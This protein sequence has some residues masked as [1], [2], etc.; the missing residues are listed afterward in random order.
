[1]HLLAAQP[2]GFVDDA[3]VITRIAQQP[4]DI[5]V[6]SAADT[7]LALLAAAWSQL[8][9]EAGTDADTLGLPTLRLA[10]L[11]HLRQPASVDLYLDDVLQHARVIVIDHLGGESYWPY[12]TERI[13]ELCRARGIA[14]AMFS[15][16]TSEDRNLL[17]KGTVEAEIARTLW[18]YLRE[19]GAANAR[20]FHRYLAATFFGQPLQVEP[21]RPLPTVA[22]F[23]PRHEVATVENWQ[24]DW[25]PGAPCVPLLFYRAHLQAGNTAVFAHLCEALQAHG[26]NPL[27]LALLS[28]K[29][30]VGVATVRRLCAEHRAALILNT[31][32]F[33]QA[34]LDS[35]A[36]S[37]GWQ[38]ELAAA[39]AGLA[40]D[41]P[42]LQLILSGG[43]EAGWQEDPQGLAPRDIAMHVALPEVDGRIITRAI[44]FK[45]LDHHNPLTQS[46]VVQYRAHPERVA[47]VAE[48]A[49]RWC[50]LRA[51][52]NAD[53]RLALVLANYPTREGRLGNGVG[54]DTPASVIAIL[55]ALRDEGYALG[56][57][58]ADGDALMARLK[59]GIT[60]DPA[61][62]AL[63]PA[64]QSL[65][66]A[67]YLA[68]FQRLPAASRGAVLARWGAPEA[69]PMLRQGRF[70]L[71][72]LRCGKV[73]IGIQ[74]ARGYE[75]DPLANYHDPDLVPPH[76]YLAFYC[77]LR[78]VWRCDALVHVGKHGNLEWLPGKSVALSGECWPDIALGPL[79]HLY[80][81]IVNDPGEGTQAKRR[82][83]AVIIDHL[84]PPLTRA[85]SYGPTRDLERQVDEY[86]EALMLDGRR[87]EEL[88]RSILAHILRHDLHRDLGLEAPRSAEEEQRL[89]NRTDAYLCELKESQIRDGLHIFGRSPADRL[90]RDTLLALARHPVGDGRG[91]NHGLTRALATD[92]GLGDDF[93]PLDADWSQPW[94]G[95]RPA[96]LAA[97]G[98]GPWRN[99][100]D[101]RERL[102]LLALQVLE[103]G[104]PADGRAREHGLPANTLALEHGLLADGLEPGTRMQPA[105][106]S[107]SPLAGE[108][109]GE[110]SACKGA[111]AALPLSPSPSPTG[112][113]GSQDEDA[114]EQGDSRAAD[115]STTSRWPR[116]T[117]VLARINGDLRPRLDACGPQELQQLLRGLAG[118]FVPPGPSG[119]PSRG[120]PDVLPTGRNF[121]SVDTR[122]IPTQ[123]SWTLGL[124][125]AERMIERYL[126][127]HGDYPRAVGLSVW[128]TAT[129]RTGGD[130]IAQAFAL[131]GV[132]PKWADGSHRVADFEIL[133]M[134]LLDRPRIDVTLRV[135]GFFRDAFANVIRLFD[136]AVQAVAELDE[137]A[138]V[139]P[140]RAR[141]AAEAAA[142]QAE[143]LP[144]GQAR[145]RAS[146]RV[147]G[148]KPGAY[149]AGLQGL[150][151]SGNWE[152]DADLAAA[153]L[154]WGG[155]AY[156]AD[157]HGSEAR[158]TL[159]RR[160]AG[161]DL[162]MHNQ[163][164]REHDLLD[165]DDYYQFQG[166]MTAAVRHLAGRQPTVL[167][168]DHSNPQAPAVRTLEEEISRVVR[169]RVTNPKWL[170]GVKRHG[171]KGAFEIAA[172]VDY[173]YAYDATARVVRD[174]QYARV[175]DACLEDADT[176]A[177]LQQHNPDAL[178]EICERL[179]EAMQRGLWQ[180]P[181]DYR[182]RVER[183]LLAAERKLE[184]A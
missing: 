116:S 51:L 173:L 117:A 184:E 80:P 171:Y 120:R 134:S 60:N 181:G 113:E 6:L 27:P 19:G 78:E 86:Y 72:G 58:P 138:E 50:R 2:G 161:I 64:Q 11:L 18:R 62:W 81:F 28:L 36:G 16:D 9:A 92:L 152:S 3:G 49:Q 56:E 55:E 131:I 89:L 32:A 115:E 54:L 179:L 111:V 148:A 76:H 107:P 71:A 102:E 153:Y 140:I 7:T 141:I 165:S 93:D 70:M 46:D 123:T 177:F 23:H 164:N 12:G 20:N 91:G 59:E 47:F 5:V 176:R 167:F 87:A 155:Y 146:H 90:R 135:S 43:N 10:N 83:Q 180:A 73:F 142:L 4:A 82:A 13:G 101:T 65:A 145:R 147:F 169:A 151:D 25:Q 119:A 63:R 126:Q 1:M 162:V 112:G 166:G 125:S 132:R 160:L 110:G 183:H 67:D 35:A 29:D 85:E 45:G 66:M 100:G 157:D 150:I 41:V 79:P 75:L 39:A 68:F 14:L 94:Q 121:Y 88:R 127:E 48:L 130:D 154:N 84:M 61:Q 95:A 149:G 108:G 40:G 175:A 174:D 77:W 42:V 136:A 178:R 15:G 172:T 114:S 26:M 30:A 97:L 143:G 103:H 52:P 37:G 170:A 8:A 24:A 104:L 168:G 99:T 122:A 53:K 118:R 22:L 106:S 158:D 34:T 133:P 57:L 163:D 156:G 33:S 21:P 44:S 159:A 137:E 96:L 31:T 69:D 182:E 144:A 129:M 128:G 124:R 17:Q 74:P 139:N 38:A 98:E 105:G 109:R